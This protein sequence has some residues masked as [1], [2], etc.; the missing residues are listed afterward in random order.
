MCRATIEEVAIDN[1]WHHTSVLTFFNTL[2]LPFL[3]YIILRNYREVITITTHHVYH[4]LNM[5]IIFY[6]FLFLQ[7]SILNQEDYK[8]IT[9]SKIA[10]KCITLLRYIILN[11][12]FMCVDITYKLLCYKFKLQTNIILYLPAVQIIFSRFYLSTSYI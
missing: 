4:I 3:Y 11:V 6:T 9:E 12:A 2:P 7:Y 5:V 1:T 10:F 8:S